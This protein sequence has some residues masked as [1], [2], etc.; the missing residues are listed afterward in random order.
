MVV[1]IV[2]VGWATSK[3]GCLPISG[4]HPVL[5]STIHLFFRNKLY[6]RLSFR[7]DLTCCSCF[8]LDFSYSLVFQ[9]IFHLQNILWSPLSFKEGF[10]SGTLFPYIRLQQPPFLSN[11]LWYIPYKSWF[12]HFYFSLLGEYA[13][14]INKSHCK[15]TLPKIRNKYS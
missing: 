9:N 15:N 7:M 5:Y 2:D 13:K 4:C 8:R 10:S 6:F 12:L 11:I 14:S 3:S 1:N